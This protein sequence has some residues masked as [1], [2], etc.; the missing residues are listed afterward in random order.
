MPY[1]PIVALRPSDWIPRPFISTPSWSAQSFKHLQLP[2]SARQSQ[3]DRHDYSK[4]SV[5]VEVDRLHSSWR[6]RDT[7][8]HAR[9]APVGHPT[10]A[11]ARSA[12]SGA[13]AP[14]RCL[15][16]HH[17]VPSHSGCWADG[18]ARRNRR[19]QD[20][21]PLSRGGFEPLGFIGFGSE[22][23]GRMIRS[24]LVI[25][26]DGD[27]H[28]FARQYWITSDGTEREWLAVQYEYTRRRGP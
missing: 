22:V 15:G 8:R 3:A 21:W 23:E 12:G 9:R 24:N 27:D 11:G 14:C 4:W 19:A 6:V 26:R 25:T 18:F 20:G 5:G 17:D 28:E 2:N 13:G 16:R 7:G 1:L 10:H